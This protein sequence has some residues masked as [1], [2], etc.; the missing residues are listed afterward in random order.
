MCDSNDQSE[1]LNLQKKCIENLETSINEIKEISLKINKELN[2][3][4]ENLEELNNDTT[5][6]SI[7]IKKSDKQTKTAT[8]EYSKCVI[9]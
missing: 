5:L 7:E 4:N 3:Q 2:I 8:R 1:I 9:C 6:A